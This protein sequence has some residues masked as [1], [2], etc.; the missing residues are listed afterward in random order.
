MSELQKGIINVKV[1]EKNGKVINVV[2]VSE[3]DEIIIVTTGG[4]VV[5]CPVNQIRTSGRNAVGVKVMRLKDK[6]KI[7][8]A[9]R[10][11]AKEEEGGDQQQLELLE[12]KKGTK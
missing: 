6:D 12:K 3:E 9:T 10:V 5:R 11:V 1:S 7:A 4:M 2:T 8:S